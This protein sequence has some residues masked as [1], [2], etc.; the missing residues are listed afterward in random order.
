M[1]ELVLTPQ[2]T[3]D[4]L[5]AILRTHPDGHSELA[6]LGV[7]FAPGEYDLATI[8]HPYEIP[9]AFKNV[10]AYGATIRNGTLGA[11]SDARVL[12]ALGFTLVG[13]DIAPLGGDPDSAQYHEFADG[14]FR[15]TEGSRDGIGCDGAE[16]DTLG[17]TARRGAPSRLNPWIMVLRRVKCINW[18]GAGNKTHNLYPHGRHGVLIVEDSLFAGGN[19]GSAIK[20]TR[21]RVEVRR[22]RFFAESQMVDGLPPIGERSFSKFIDMPAC[23]SSVIEANEFYASSSRTASSGLT[24]CLWYCNR[25]ELY[26]TD[27]PPPADITFQVAPFAAFSFDFGESGIKG[28]LPYVEVLLNGSPVVGAQVQHDVR[29]DW[30]VTLPHDAVPVSGVYSVSLR[31]ELGAQTPLDKRIRLT[32]HRTGDLLM[33]S[34]FIHAEPA[35]L[36]RYADPDWWADAPDFEHLVDGNLFVWVPNSVNPNPSRRAIRSEGTFPTSALRQFSSGSK[37]HLVPHGWRERTLVRRRNNTYRGWR[38]FD[39]TI[40][41]HQGSPRPD[42]PAY[43]PVGDPRFTIPNPIPSTRCVDEGGEVFE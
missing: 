43:G 36:A 41:M 40:W 23:G 20:T 32:V 16:G 11:L 34:S 27:D 29:S 12:R 17:R 25:R 31:S 13:A 18:I 22:T 35:T 14:V 6:P 8:G 5:R 33:V 26:G 10:T 39:Q 24:E 19:S 37:W 38:E 4:D 28:P 9:R 2:T 3:R 1:S 15:D 30:R 7:R 21:N 42:E